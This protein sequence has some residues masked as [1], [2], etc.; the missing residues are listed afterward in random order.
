MIKTY[1]SITSYFVWVL[2]TRCGSHICINMQ[3]IRNSRR[4]GRDEVVL[5]LG[6]GAKVATLVIG[7][8][9]LS[10]STRLVIELSNYYYVPSIR[11]NIISIS[12][13]IMD[14]FNFE[15]RNKGISIF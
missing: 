13:L 12:C 6:N 10:L 2:D 11:K 7:F 8:C 4:L 14:G 9:S 1:F 5:Q 3:T 15:I